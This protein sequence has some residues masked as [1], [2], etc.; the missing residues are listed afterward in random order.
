MAVLPSAKSAGICEMTPSA[1]IYRHTTMIVQPFCLG[2]AFTYSACRDH[3]GYN[4]LLLSNRV[5]LLG[6][7]GRRPYRDCPFR[8]WWLFSTRFQLC[9]RKR[10]TCGGLRFLHVF[11]VVSRFSLRHFFQMVSINNGWPALFL[12]TTAFHAILRSTLPLQIT[13]SFSKYSTAW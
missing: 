8:F 12:G 10:D 5:F 13:G 6:C 9:A 11:F 7:T 3:G 1:V 4:A 2:P